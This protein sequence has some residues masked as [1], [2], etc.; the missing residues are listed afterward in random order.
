[1]LA[2]L[3]LLL[4]CMNVANIL[5][6][7]ATMRQREMAIRAAMGA[8]RWRLI[9]QMLTESILLALFGGIGGLTLGV[10][11]SSAVALLLPAGRFPIHL[12]FGFDWRVF[13]YAMTAAL[14]TGA[15]VGLWPALRAGRA[16]VNSVLQSGG[17]SDTAGVSRH[18]L[19]SVLVV[20]QVA[21]SLVLLIVA[22]LF[23]RSL[24]RAQRANLGFDPDQVLNLTLDPKEVGYDEARTKNFYRRPRS[25]GTRIAR[26]AIG[27]P[28]V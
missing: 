2:A 25:Q 13:A 4:A 18:R 10:W 17:R 20:A 7:R 26:R 23:V 15:I 14:F 19:R 9:R 21:G 3:V 27:K 1:M 8:N 28:R 24:M 11:A 5:L 22:G 16:D 6:V 12:D